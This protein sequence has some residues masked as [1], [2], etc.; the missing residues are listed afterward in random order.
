[1][2]LK[3]QRLDSAVQPS[4]NQNWSNKFNSLGKYWG[5]QSHTPIFPL[6]PSQQEFQ[7]NT[8]V[9]LLELPSAYS[10]EEALLLCQLSA[11][12]WIGWIPSYGEAVLKNSQFCAIS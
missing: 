7:P 12:E 3:S 1:M 5:M 6:H 2:K 4:Q 11:D 9:Q 10:Y 8:W